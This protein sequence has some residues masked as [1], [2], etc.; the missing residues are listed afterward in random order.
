VGTQIISGDF[1]Q[2]SEK[3]NVLI[4]SLDI[5]VSELSLI[6]RREKTEIRLM[7]P[8]DLACEI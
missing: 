6:N 3:H 8:K 1:I 7:F 4:L 5:Y 2:Q